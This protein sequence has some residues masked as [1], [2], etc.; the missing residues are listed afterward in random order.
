LLSLSAKS[1]NPIPEFLHLRRV[2][3]APGRVEH[4]RDEQHQGAIRP[5]D[6]WEIAAYQEAVDGAKEAQKESRAWRAHEHLVGQV[7]DLLR[8]ADRPIPTDLVRQRLAKSKPAVVA[9]LTEAESRGLA[10]RVFEG[11][12]PRG[13]RAVEATRTDPDR[14]GPTRTGTAWSDRPTALFRGA[15]RSVSPWSGRRTGTG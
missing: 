7:V 15:V 13:W 2:C 1:A 8:K 10:E 6:P 9:A 12:R 5:A 11:N 3:R 4:F 14:P